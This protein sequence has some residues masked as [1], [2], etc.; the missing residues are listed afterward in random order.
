MGL[1]DVP[2][3]SAAA[4]PTP[5]R[6]ATNPR[7]ETHEHRE[8]PPHHRRDR[9]R[10]LLLRR[11]HHRSDHQRKNKTAA[12]STTPKDSPRATT[13]KAEKPSAAAP[14]TPAHAKLGQPVR[15]GK[16]EFTVTAVKYG[17]AQVGGSALNKTAQGQF[18]LISVTVKNIGQEPQTFDGSNQT[19]KSAG[20]AEFDN[21]TTAEIYANSQ[22]QTFLE[23]IN[24]GN[25]VSGVIVF[26]IP[27]GEK[28]ASLVLHDSMF[29]GGVTV[30]LT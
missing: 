25:Q 10:A 23:K 13:A 17:V 21:D 6:A 18:V 3:R 20:G 5:I 7:Q 24:P 4:Q 27:K 29:S 1:R 19:A 14:T 16:F 26:D 9:P 12:T 30:D 11:R 15:D 22:S 8:D 2:E 28:L